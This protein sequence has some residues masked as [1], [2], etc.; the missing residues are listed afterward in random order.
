MH[1]VDPHSRALVTLPLTIRWTTSGGLRSSRF[2]VFV[3]R[4]PVQPGQSLDVVANASCQKAARCLLGDHRVGRGVYTTTADQVTISRVRS[5]GADSTQTHEAS[6]IVLNSAGHRQGEAVWYVEF[7][8]RK[9]AG[10]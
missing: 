2:A 1:L 7:R 6:V 9:P 10:S 3:D 5:N 8:T 4:A